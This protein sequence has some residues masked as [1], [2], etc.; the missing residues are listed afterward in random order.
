MVSKRKRRL[1]YVRTKLKKA[2][3]NGLVRYKADL[4]I[5]PETH[6][7]TLQE[8]IPSLLDSFIKQGGVIQLSFT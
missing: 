2:G 4:A 7:Q 5:I 6:Y 8:P 1:Y 3:F